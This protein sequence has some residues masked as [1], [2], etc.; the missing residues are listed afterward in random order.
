MDHHNAEDK[1]HQ[2]A[3]GVAEQG[4]GHRQDQ[5]PGWDIHEQYFCSA[6]GSAFQS[7]QLIARVGVTAT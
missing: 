5:R 4:Q 6:T 7:K 1:P 2:A 3:D